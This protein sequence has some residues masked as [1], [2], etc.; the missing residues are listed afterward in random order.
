[1]SKIGNY[2]LD[3]ESRGE[4]IYDEYRLDYVT[5]KVFALRTDLEY[6]EWQIQSLERDIKIKKAELK[7][8]ERVQ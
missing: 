6:L 3:L 7:T 5:P 1:M 8:M 2:V 4:L